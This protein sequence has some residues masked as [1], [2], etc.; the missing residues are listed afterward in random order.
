[1]AV[2]IGTAD[3]RL[4]T[5]HVLLRDALPHSVRA[6]LVYS[7][8]PAL[9][10]T[11]DQ[12]QLAMPPQHCS[13]DGGI[14]VDVGG[15][16]RGLEMAA[17]L[18]FDEAFG[19][20]GDVCIRPALFT[21]HAL[22]LLTPDPSGTLLPPCIPAATCPARPERIHREA[23]WSTTPALPTIRSPP[24][25]TTN[26]LQRAKA[27][28]PQASPPPYVIAAMLLPRTFFKS[29]HLEPTGMAITGAV[30]P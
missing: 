1:M 2:Q 21:A 25:Q 9:C 24:H 3:S 26:Q 16:A 30:R 29:A 19:P 10:P 7:S 12:T 18:T 4:G 17:F 15:T 22:L 11:E 6:S 14:G 5:H 23:R 20:N 27:L 28:H 8:F 13:R